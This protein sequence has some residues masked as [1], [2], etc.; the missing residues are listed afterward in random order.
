MTLIMRI[1][2]RTPKNWFKRQ[3]KKV[4]GNIAGIRAENLME[5]A[6]EMPKVCRLSIAI[7]EP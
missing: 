7:T 2:R 5:S 1:G 4:L 3:A 6:I